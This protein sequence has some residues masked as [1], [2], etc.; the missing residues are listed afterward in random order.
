MEKSFSSACGASWDYPPKALCGRAEWLLL[1]D[2][3]LHF[4]S[5]APCPPWR[6]N[7][8]L[9]KSQRTQEIEVVW[10]KKLYLAKFVS[11]VQTLIVKLILKV[12]RRFLSVRT[13][14]RDKKS[15]ASWSWRRI[16][17]FQSTILGSRLNWWS[18][19]NQDATKNHWLCLS[20]AV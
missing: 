16:R 19:S 5:I 13:K 12:W 7:F 20:I 8:L 15:S 14:P 4:S 11:D 2:P 9:I 17:R 6:L 18:V 3:F 1:C 10:P